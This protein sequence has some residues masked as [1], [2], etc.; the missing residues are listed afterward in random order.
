MRKSHS[1]PLALS[2][3]C[4]P[5]APICFHRVSIESGGFEQQRVFCGGAVMALQH[6]GRRRVL[7]DSSAG[8]MLL[9]VHDNSETKRSGRCTGLG[10]GA[11]GEETSQRQRLTEKLKKMQVAKLMPKFD[12]E[13]MMAK[14]KGLLL[15]LTA[16]VIPALSQ[17]RSKSLSL[18]PKR[19]RRISR[20][21]VRH[22]VLSA[23]TSR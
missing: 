13:D 11:A 4:E 23:W 1:F 7:G 17:R 6:E 19:F 12:F 8:E 21:R 10:V 22:L 2:T 3:G 9:S 15:S 16:F 14:S 18:K 5:E 20:L